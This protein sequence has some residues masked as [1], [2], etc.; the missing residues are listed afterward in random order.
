MLSIQGRQ[1][2]WLLAVSSP[3]PRPLPTYLHGPLGLGSR[4]PHALLRGQAKTAVHAGYGE[5]ECKRGGD[6][7]KVYLYIY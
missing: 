4:P 6:H 2:M 5:G 1:P 3:P 7:I